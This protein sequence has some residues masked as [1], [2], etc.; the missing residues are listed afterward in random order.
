MLSGITPMIVE[1]CPFTRRVLPITSG[2][3]PYR[4][5]QML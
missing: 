5:F 1:G 2:S 4:F 3:A